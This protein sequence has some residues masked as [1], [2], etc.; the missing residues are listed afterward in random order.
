MAKKKRM[1]LIALNALFILLPSAFFLASKAAA[2]SFDSWFYG[3]QVL[4]LVA[5]AANITMLGLNIRDGLRMTG[6]IGQAPTSQGV[7]PAGSILE[8]REGGP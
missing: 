7:A 5:G 2:G 6:R 3:I 1:P 8:D 4:E